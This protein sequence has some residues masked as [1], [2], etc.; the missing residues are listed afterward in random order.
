MVD[1]LSGGPAGLPELLARKA[2]LHLVELPV[3]PTDDPG[4]ILVE[5]GFKLAREHEVE[6][7]FA[8][9]NGPQTRITQSNLYHVGV[10]FQPE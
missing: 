10:K 7:L 8:I 4:W 5:E 3:A 2:N 1:P 9:G 6:L